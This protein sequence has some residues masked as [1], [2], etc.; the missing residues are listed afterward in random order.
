M[1]QSTSSRYRG[2]YRH[3]QNTRR[4]Q[5]SMKT[6]RARGRV[7]QARRRRGARVPRDHAFEDARAQRGEKDGAWI[8]VAN[9]SKSART[10]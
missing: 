5:R 4:W 3:I 6:L 9:T 8:N 1:R 7:K 10:D 2:D